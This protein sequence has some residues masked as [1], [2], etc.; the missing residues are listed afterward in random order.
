MRQPTERGEPPGDEDH[1]RSRADPERRDRP[2]EACGRDRGERHDR[3]GEPRL[4]RIEPP[5]VDQQ[6]HE[7]EERRDEASG[8]EQERRV[9]A[10][11]RPLRPA[12]A[13]ATACTPRSATSA[14]RTAGAWT[15]KI[16]SQPQ[17]LRE[18]P[19]DRGPERGTD[20]SGE[21][22]DARRACLRSCSLAQEVERCADD[23]RTCDTLKSATCDEHTERRREAA[24][25]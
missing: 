6:D 24:E 16:D 8:D 1:A 12:R 21:R 17:Q 19:A 23:G 14:R 25:E 13:R 20:D 7:Q 18:D 2:P 3:H 9:R 11:V 22:P 4:Q 10:D 5:A 15:K